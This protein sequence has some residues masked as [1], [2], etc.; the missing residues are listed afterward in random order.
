MASQQLILGRYEA[1]R[2]FAERALALAEGLG[3]DD[4]VVRA[5]QN[6]GAARCE[7]GDAGGLADL[8]SALRLG[9]DRGSGTETAISYTNLAM[10]LWVLDGPAIALQVWDSAVEFSRVRG[11]STEAYWAECGRLEVLFDL[12]RWDEVLETAEAVEAWDREEGGGQMRTF[13]QVYR[14]MVLT[15]R[16]EV[17]PA[18]LL[19]EEFLPR[20]RILQRAEFLAPGLTLAAVLE[21]LRGHDAMAGQLVEEY[22]RTTAGHDAYRLH[23]LPDAAR[24]L[25]AT[26]RL[27]RLETLLA[28]VTEDQ[29]RTVRTRNALETARAVAAEA[30][31]DHDDAAGRYARCA[32]AWLSYGSI[33]ERAHALLGEGRSR[34][35]LGDPEG[36]DRLR[37][38]REVY[39]ALGAAASVRDVDALLSDAAAATS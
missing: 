21:E 22:V 7:L 37:A 9:L 12:G 26:G 34:R 6:L 19:E 39:A 14:A 31:G 3:L 4:E 18:V 35:A 17:Q 38:A 33:P 30:R 27:E 5:R 16:G 28:G 10:Q 11:F 2:D 13:A 15:R 1:C 24:V 32:A 25:A 8:W 20:L 36:G 23:F 29:P